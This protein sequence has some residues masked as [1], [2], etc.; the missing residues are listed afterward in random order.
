MKDYCIMWFD[1][2]KAVIALNNTNVM[3]SSSVVIVK[4][5]KLFEE[6]ECVLIQ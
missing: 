1:T 3:S 2:E 6:F 5:V 4:R